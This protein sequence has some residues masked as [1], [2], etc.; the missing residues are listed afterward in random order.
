MENMKNENTS[1][2]YEPQHSDYLIYSSWVA[3]YEFFSGEGTWTGII[4]MI[5]Q[6]TTFRLQIQAPFF[7]FSGFQT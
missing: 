5:A 6:G 4:Q 7:L 3:C 1:T 2:L